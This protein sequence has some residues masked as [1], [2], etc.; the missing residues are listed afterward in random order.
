[1]SETGRITGIGGIFVKSSNPDRLMIWYRDILGLETTEW[2]VNFL[3][4]DE[5]HGD[6][7]YQV[8]SNFKEDTPYFGPSD[9]PFMINFRVENLVEFARTLKTRGVELLDDGIVEEPYGKFAWIMDPDGT[10]IELWE[11][12]GGLPEE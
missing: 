12:I 2:G 5:P 10:K 7:S 6:Q 8:W 11:Q 4:S 3:A 9:K 1:M